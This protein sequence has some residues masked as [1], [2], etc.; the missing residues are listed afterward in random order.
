MQ[1]AR[2]RLTK[3]KRKASLTPATPP[4]A[5]VAEKGE[6]GLKGV[7][8]FQALRTANTFAFISNENQSLAISLRGGRIRSWNDNGL[9]RSSNSMANVTFRR[10]HFEASSEQGTKVPALCLSHGFFLATLP[11]RVSGT[12][13]VFEGSTTTC[14]KCR[15][16]ARL[17]NCK[18]KLGSREGDSPKSG[19]SQDMFEEYSR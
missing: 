15:R 10:C 14:S 13:V 11:L 6:R 16:P 12:A 1:P 4:D 5:G 9:A 8:P 2:N 17:L 19:S 7:G 18:L 3:K